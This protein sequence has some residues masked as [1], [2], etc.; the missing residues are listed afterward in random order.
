MPHIH[1]YVPANETKAL[2]LATQHKTDIRIA[3]AR[4]FEYDEQDVTLIGHIIDTG[5]MALSDN[6]LPL[7]FVVDLG[8]R[9]TPL[10]DA[11]AQEALHILTVAAPGITTVH[12]GIWVREMQSN[13]F[14]EH[15]PK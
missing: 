7:E 15:V 4:L 3:I 6:V 13:G 1:V 9:K 14:A 10:S 11:S 8:T 5:E 12:H 2:A